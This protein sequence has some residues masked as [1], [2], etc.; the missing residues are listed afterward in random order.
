[1]ALLM[2][3]AAFGAG[4][5]RLAH[6]RI[7]GSQAVE[8]LLDGCLALVVDELGQVVGRFARKSAVDMAICCA[9]DNTWRDSGWS[10][11]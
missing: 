2:A 5:E 7:L 10:A 9:L 1:M 6:V 3:V 4:I 11:S 8:Q